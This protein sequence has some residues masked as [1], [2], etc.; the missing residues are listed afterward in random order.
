M[1]IDVFKIAQKVNIHLGHFYKRNSHQELS[2]IDQSGHTGYYHR[3][4][5]IHVESILSMGILEK[6]KNISFIKNSFPG[7]KP[8]VN[9]TPDS[10]CI[11]RSRWLLPH[12]FVCSKGPMN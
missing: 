4:H 11:Q 5:S 9:K 1:K 10:M 7:V 3:G 2:K 6:S 12:V 8:R